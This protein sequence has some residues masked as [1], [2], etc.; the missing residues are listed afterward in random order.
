MKNNIKKNKNRNR[1]F[2]IV[3]ATLFVLSLIIYSS[4]SG[5]PLY[6]VT[7]PIS[8]IT[9]PIHS[10]LLK[11]TSGITGFIE[12]VSDSAKIRDENIAL[13]EKN[14]LLEQKVKELEE[15]GRRWEELKTAF[16]IKDI[17]SDYELLGASILTREIGDWFD[18][19]RVNIG[20]NEGIVIDDSTS[21]AVVDAQMNLIG[22]VLSSDF[23][24]SKILPILDEGSVV[25]AKLNTASGSAVR[26]RGDITLKGEGCCIVDKIT[27]F[28]SIQ[29]GDEV[30]T[31]GLGGLY[32]PGIPIG[33]II[34][35]RND[36]QKIEKTAVLK[37]YTDYKTLTDVFIMKGTV[38]ISE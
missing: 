6:S 37:V 8:F 24:S 21:Y 29:V 9:N 12:T 32:P 14:A 1:V 2:I 7:S 31:S 38:D 30:I 25:S 20:T 16:Q 3:I 34:E 17:F 35:L 36:D 11:T 4:I 26:I 18:V 27:D 10:F 28:T 23:V 13:K 22:R 19:F 33:V 5:S 15:N